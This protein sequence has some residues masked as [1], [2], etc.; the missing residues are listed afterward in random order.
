MHKV[1]QWQKLSLYHSSSCVVG[2]IR[3]DEDVDRRLQSDIVAIDLLTN[4]QTG[5]TAK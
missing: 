5:D 1:P 2:I 3:A 4:L